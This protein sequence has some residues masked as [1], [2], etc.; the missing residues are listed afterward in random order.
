MQ[1]SADKKK[2]ILL[3]VK[4]SI[5]LVVA[6]AVA[7]T[8]FKAWDQ[9]AGYDWSLSPFWLVAAG[10]FY[11]LGLLPAGLFWYHV[12]RRLGQDAKLGETLRAYYVG[13]LGKYVPGKA[14]VVIIRAGMIRGDRVNTSLAATSVF[15]ET[16]TM[17][18]VGAFLAAAVLAVWCRGH[19]LLL[20]L[21]LGLML[22]A[23]LPTIPPVFRFLARLARVGKS[24]PAVWEKL[25]SVG[26][27]TLLTGWAAMTVSWSVL[28]VSLWATLKAIGIEGM[29]LLAH[30]PQY[31]GTVSLAMVAGF[32]SLIPG[33][34]GVRDMVL[35]ELML[36][37]FDRVAC[38][39]EPAATAVV[40]AVL[41]RVTWL[42]SELILSAVLYA[43]YVRDG[44]K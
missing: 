17:M 31:L 25:S 23:G 44:K 20:T 36:P 16:L 1:E 34:L 37:Y 26:C 15:F 29:D 3:A 33:G 18:A 13:H 8:L 41:L 22:M 24:D 28:A 39:I 30:F 12:L 19:G 11:L 10:C 43:S 14:M 6:W 4:L 5:I 38:P 9:L 7:D 42:L 40:S 32:L 21:A 27:G 2:R 35:A